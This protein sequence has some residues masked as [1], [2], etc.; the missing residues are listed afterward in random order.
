LGLRGA[1]LALVGGE[2]VGLTAVVEAA[3]RVRLGDARAAFAGGAEEYC[4]FVH[5]ALAARGFVGEEAAAP[6]SGGD[7]A[8]F[9]GEGAALLYLEEPGTGAAEREPP[10]ARLLGWG[11]ARGGPEGIPGA[12]ERAV[13]EALEDAGV[14]AEEIDV[15][16]GSAC[17]SALDAAEAEGL[18]RALRRG[19]GEPVAVTCPKAALG[20][21]F[22]FTS[23]AQALV[24]VEALRSGC[25]PATA[26]ASRGGGAGAEPRLLPPGFT[27]AR[28]ALACELRC[29][30][31]VA[32]NRRGAAVAGV[33]G[34]T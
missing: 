5:A 8:P 30:L 7:G 9:L 17:G 11:A 12:V 33:F 18:A 14:R 10:L 26:N 31:A 25:V 2:E 28:A 13:G 22:A 20:E 27:L 32:A 3:E 19:R 6:Y 15:V 34:A 21:G 23:G 16:V 29:A 24:A 4:D 1:S